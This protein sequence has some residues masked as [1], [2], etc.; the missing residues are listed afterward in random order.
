MRKDVERVE[1]LKRG[2]I[3]PVPQLSP[4]RMQPQLH[5][6]EGGE[7]ITLTK[8]EKAEGRKDQEITTE[9]LPEGARVGSQRAVFGT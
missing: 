4:E 7:E 3:K 5:G 8:K 2:W 6:G 1:D 9:A